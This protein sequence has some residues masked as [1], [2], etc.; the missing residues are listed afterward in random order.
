MESQDTI[1][2]VVTNRY[3][4]RGQ[5]GAGGMGVVYVATDRLTKQDV[6]LKRLLSAQHLPGQ[7]PAMQVPLDPEATR[8][9]VGQGSGSPWKSDN[10]ATL[11]RLA[12]AQEFKVLA[13]LRHPNIISVLDYGFEDGYQPFLTMELVPAARTILEAAKGQDLAAKV[14]LIC[15]V[16]EALIYLHRRNIL[17]RDLKPANVLVSEGRVRVLDFGIATHVADAEGLVGTV[18]Y[19]APEI[20]KGRSASIASDL[21]SLGLMVY[22]IL[23]GVYPFAQNSSRGLMWEMM[24]TAPDLRPLDGLTGDLPA[25][26]PA[27]LLREVVAR[28]LAKRP[29]QR[30]PDAGSALAE[31]NAAIGQAQP[32][33]AL[34]IRESF[35]RAA[36]FVGRGDELRHFRSVLAE[37]RKGHGSSWLIGGESGVG[38]TRLGEELRIH[39]LVQGAAVWTSHPGWRF[40]PFS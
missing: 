5:L 33:E 19:M 35:L 4:L 6:A 16:L 14:Q 31:L 30:F 3:V 23:T 32:P 28:L 10:S 18:R 15:Q 17:H 26:A 40:C 9:T 29:E 24:N 8:S 38:K 13:S 22:E 36:E 7:A 21:F 27:G 39:A 34:A 25:G 20:Q 1:P 2:Q 37:A 12:L 11:H